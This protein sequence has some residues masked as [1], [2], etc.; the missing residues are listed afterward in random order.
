[1]ILDKKQ[2]ILIIFLILSATIS[3]FFIKRVYKFERPNIILI[4]IDAL[5]QDHLSCYGYN[6]N[7][8]PNID[9]LAKDSV[10]FTQA[11]SQGSFTPTALYSIL[12]STYPSTHGVYKFGI[13]VNPCLM[14]LPEVLKNNGYY[15]GFI[16]GRGDLKEFD[17]SKIEKEFDT[18]YSGDNKFIKT[19]EVIQNATE[20]L[21]LNKKKRF[22]LWLFCYDTH[23]PYRPPFPYNEEFVNDKLRYE[24]VRYAPLGN[25]SMKDYDGYKVIP[26]VVVENNI[27]DVNYY[28]SQYDG[29]IRFLDRELGILFAELKRLKLHE[30]TLIVI[31]SDHGESMGEHDFY[32]MHGQNLYDE[33]IKVPLII[34]YKIIGTNK[35]I[36]KQVQSI[37]IL[38]TILDIAKIKAPR[39]VSGVSL[40]PL[41][42]N[43]R[44]PVRYA[45]SEA[46]VLK[47]EC[48]RTED[49]KLI[50]KGKNDQYELYNL[51]DD[52]KE[53]KNLADAEK[54][55]FQSL[56]KKLHDWI[57][58][59]RP[60]AITQK[61][62]LDDATKEKLRSLGYNQ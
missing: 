12:T 26:Q 50:Y 59:E 37:D 1:M 44:Y 10:V 9:K 31:T 22:F 35:R 39:E 17:F 28:I 49:W 15:L 53:T 60:K 52:P 58:E 23:A 7:T 5:R 13:T 20:W 8:S 41:I 2:K 54:T 29:A 21:R 40:L 18:F 27:G 14:T 6:R 55:Q 19:D 56:K 32:F 51:K 61:Q 43:G 3:F 30:N 11:I 34:K 48:I 57:N 45:F 62:F 25:G 33:L 24:N 46:P 42:K 16:S 36:D 4:T 47:Q 38:P